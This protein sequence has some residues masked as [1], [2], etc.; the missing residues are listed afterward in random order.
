M[1]ICGAEELPVIMV[2]AA[3]HRVSQL[4]SGTPTIKAAQSRACLTLSLER[5]QNCSFID[6]VTITS[7]H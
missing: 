4:N 5:L 6:W 2:C 7:P 3:C 1:G